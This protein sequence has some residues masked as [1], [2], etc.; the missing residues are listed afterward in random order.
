MLINQSTAKLSWPAIINNLERFSPDSI[1]GLVTTSSLAGAPDAPRSGSGSNLYE[2]QPLRELSEQF[3]WQL[4]SSWNESK[5]AMDVLRRNSSI[6]RIILLDAA[7][8]VVHERKEEEDNGNR[9]PVAEQQISNLVT[10]EKA[11]TTAISADS[12]PMENYLER[13]EHSSAVDDDNN[14]VVNFAVENNEGS[15]TNSETTTTTE[16]AMQSE[17]KINKIPEH[18]E[19][20]ITVSDTKWQRILSSRVPPT[21]ALRTTR[22]TPTIITRRDVTGTEATMHRDNNIPVFRVPA[23]PTNELAMDSR[24]IRN[25]DVVDKRQQRGRCEEK[26]NKD[27]EHKMTRFFFSNS[28]LLI[29]MLQQLQEDVLD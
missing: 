23:P 7:E 2:P 4:V 28:P 21:F 24:I 1:T 3:L 14:A 8:N 20:D 19:N 18:T 15:S 6:E 5:S 10:F 17:M 13:T 29:E 16:Q 27:W 11:S 25:A 22:G 12:E 26:T 9:R